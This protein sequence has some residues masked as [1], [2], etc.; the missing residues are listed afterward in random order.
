MFLQTFRDGTAQVVHPHRDGR[1]LRPGFVPAVPGRGSGVGMRDDP[2]IGYPRSAPRPAVSSATCRSFDTTPT[3]SRR[4]GTPSTSWSG[5]DDGAAAPASALELERGLTPPLC[6]RSARHND[7]RPEMRIAFLT[8]RDTTHPDGGGSE[9]YVEQVARGLAA[10]GHEV[11]VAVRRGTRGRGRRD[12]ARRRTGS[13]G[14]GGRLTVYLRGPGLPA[15]RAGRRTT[16]S[17]TSSTDCRSRTPLVRRRGVVALVHHV[18]REQWQIIYPGLGGRVGWFVESRLVPL[19]LPRGPAPDRLRGVRRDLR[20]ARRLAD[21][22]VARNGTSRP[23]G[24]AAR[25]GRRRRGS[26]V[27]AR[28][29]PHKQIEHA[30]ALV[31]ELRGRAPR[32]GARRGRRRLVG[33]RAGRR[34]RPARA[35]GRP[36]SGTG[37]STSRRKADLLA[38]AWL[39]VLPSVRE[40][41]GIA[42]LE[43]AAAAP[44]RSPTPARGTYRVGAWTAGR[45]CWSTTRTSWSRRS[46]RCS[47][48]PHGWRGSV[49]RRANG[50][51]TFTWDEASTG[52]E[53]VLRE[54][55]SP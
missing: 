42:V 18:H 26:C 38:Q 17:S 55:Y 49:Q 16:W 44:R 20:R 1:V 21:V 37:T 29:V 13:C 54:T 15:R 35:R 41:W 28:L 50:A 14:V 30:V 9:V 4:I 22:T 5:V 52:L 8:W 7:M 11:T 23:R 31:D 36:W 2:D 53:T 19:A 33:A 45:G 51:A 24:T 25:A 48:I 43:A 40:G 47:G 46:T 12:G 10:R 6:A 39:M 32:A 3:G 27:L 34:D